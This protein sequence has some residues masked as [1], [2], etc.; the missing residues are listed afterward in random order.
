MIIRGLLF[1]SPFGSGLEGMKVISIS[2]SAWQ[3]L[4]VVWLGLVGRGLVFRVLFCW[5]RLGGSSA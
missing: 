2:V 5:S 1:S 3:V 4:W